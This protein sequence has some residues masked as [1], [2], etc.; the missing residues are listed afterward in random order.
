[1][2]ANERE[3]FRKQI[4]AEIQAQKHLIEGLKETS[5]PV[6]PDNA[7]GRLTRMEAIN[8]KSVSEASLH[9]AS[10]RLTKLERALTKVESPDFGI[11]MRCDEPIP[12]AR[13]LLLPE[14]VVCVA[15]AS[16]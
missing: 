5:K 13:I 2:E 7:I 6:A 9:S 3:E 11:C 10:L 15:C 14:S 16:R 4:E 12:R 1:M 8:S